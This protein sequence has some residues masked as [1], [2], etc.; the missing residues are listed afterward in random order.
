MANIKRSHSPTRGQQEVDDYGT[1]VLTIIVDKTERE[2]HIHAATLEKQSKFFQIEEKYG[3]REQLRDVSVKRPR[4]EETVEGQTEGSVKV[5]NDRSET[6][7]GDE[8]EERPRTRKMANYFLPHVKADAFATFTR[9]LYNKSPRRP[10]GMA[11]CKSLIRSYLLALQYEVCPL[12]NKIVDRLREF[13]TGFDFNIDGFAYLMNRQPPLD[14]KNKH[15]IVT[16][17]LMQY[18]IAQMAFDIATKGFDEFVDQNGF[19]EFFIAHNDRPLR[20]AFVQ[21]LTMHAH[22][23]SRLDDPASVRGC[24]FHDHSDKGHCVGDEDD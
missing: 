6:E 11:D 12:Q 22:E 18:F 16:N 13:H 4:V 8:H 23:V 5:E 17:N 19:F 9:F 14:P 10:E 7:A 3:S 1:P 15:E 21:E 24:V 20:L 2:F